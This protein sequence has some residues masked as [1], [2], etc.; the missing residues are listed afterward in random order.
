[1]TD[2]APGGIGPA[3]P[4]GAGQPTRPPG[5]VKVFCGQI[6]RSMQGG[7]DEA[8]MQALLSVYGEI[9]EISI[10]KDKATGESKGCA[11]VI[12]KERAGAEKAIMA[13]HGKHTMPSMS[14]TIQLSLAK[15]E[16]MEMERAD[17]KLFIGMLSRTATE[18]EVR[19]LVTPFGAVDEVYIMKDKA[20]GQSKG[21]AFVKF[22]TKEGATAVIENLHQK[23]TMPGAT[24]P[25][26]AKWADPPKPKAPAGA[27][28][29]MGGYGGLMQQQ[30][31]M[32]QQAAV[33]QQQ[34][35]MLQQQGGQWGMQPQQ[36]P[37]NLYGASTAGLPGDPA[38]QQLMAG[39]AAAANPYMQ[40][41]ALVGLGMGDRK[42]VV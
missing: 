4:G 28:G 6:G 38:L 37:Y 19:A 17:N 40:Q 31:L 34:Q 15:G 36:D 8:A 5:S 24:Q 22:S 9:V 26:I 39:Q 32:A 30:Q 16:E 23:M 33:I 10:I 41:Q 42:S 27:M 2:P 11:F 20:T 21:C 29:M 35:L 13:L 7:S 14:N 12:F 25:L 18:E 1:M 3:G